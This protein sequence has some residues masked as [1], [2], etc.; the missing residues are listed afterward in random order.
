MKAMLKAELKRRPTSESLRR[1]RKNLNGPETLKHCPYNSYFTDRMK[2]AKIDSH[3]KIRPQTHPL[4]Q[5]KP[6]S[7]S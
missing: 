4:N 7:S 5:R 6:D 1:W 2:Q 3:G